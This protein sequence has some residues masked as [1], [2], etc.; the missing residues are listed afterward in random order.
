MIMVADEDL[1]PLGRLSQDNGACRT[2]RL[3]AF[4]H[5]ASPSPLYD[6]V[7]A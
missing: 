3:T 7:C 4:A 5:T 1:K 2:N 6:T